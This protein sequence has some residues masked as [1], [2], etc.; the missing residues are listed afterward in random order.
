[1]YAKLLEP[2]PEFLLSMLLLHRTVL[3]VAYGVA[4]SANPVLERGCSFVLWH[5]KSSKPC[6]FCTTMINAQLDTIG[7][8]KENSHI[9][10]DESG[11]PVLVRIDESNVGKGDMLLP[12]R[13]RGKSIGSVSKSSRIR[14]KETIHL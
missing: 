4:Y 5:H 9:N 6:G 14:P 13:P 2:P 1:M 12:P 11:H 8:Y 3:E 7:S 10:P